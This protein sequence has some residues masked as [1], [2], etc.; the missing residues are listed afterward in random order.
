MTRFLF[1]PGTGAVPMNSD[2]VLDNLGDGAVIRS[3]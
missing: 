3:T 2:R 1:P